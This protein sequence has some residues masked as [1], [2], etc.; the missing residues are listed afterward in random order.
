MFFGVYSFL[1]IY[2]HTYIYIY[3]MALRARPAT[4][5]G[6]GW[7][8]VW[9]RVLKKQKK[10]QSKTEC[11]QTVEKHLWGNIEKQNGLLVFFLKYTQ[12]V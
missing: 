5:P 1:C 4:V 12:Q 8:G 10:M 9:V 3:P 11:E 6:D 7:V 2:T